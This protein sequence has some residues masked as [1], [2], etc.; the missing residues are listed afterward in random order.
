MNKLYR[1]F[2]NWFFE[3][4]VVVVGLSYL[5]SWLDQKLGT[6][7]NLM[8]LG[9]LLGFGMEAYNFYKLYKRSMNNKE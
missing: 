1:D 3:C 6:G 8:S 2:L 4:A 9:L 7:A 5:G